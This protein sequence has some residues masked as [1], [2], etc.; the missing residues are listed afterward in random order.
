MLHWQGGTGENAGWTISVGRRKTQGV[1]DK[2]RLVSSE[3]EVEID[4]GKEKA[5]DGD[6]IATDD[7][8]DDD[9]DD[10]RDDDDDGAELIIFLQH[11]TSPHL[12]PCTWS[13]I[14][15]SNLQLR[16]SRFRDSPENTLQDC[17]FLISALR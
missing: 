15:A 4:E 8:D 6:D 10:K 14:R 17:M 7:D 2:A 11:S 5:N 13:C 1:E 3:I 16:K 12:V 9:D